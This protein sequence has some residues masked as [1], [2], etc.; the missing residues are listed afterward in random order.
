MALPWGEEF[1]ADVFEDLA[2]GLHGETVGVVF[3]PFLSAWDVTAARGAPLEAAINGGVAKG[4]VGLLAAGAA[5]E[6][7][8]PAIEGGGEEIDR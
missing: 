1:Q 7:V 8:G 4:F 6:V 5:D 2:F 3:G